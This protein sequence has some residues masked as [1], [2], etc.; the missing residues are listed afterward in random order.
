MYHPDD[1]V[2]DNPNQS[3]LIEQAAEMLYGLIHARY[4]LTN[5]GI[6]QMLEKYHAGD[7]GHCPRVYCENQLMLPIG[8]CVNHCFLDHQ[9]SECTNTL[10]RQVY[11]TSQ[12]RRWSSCTVR[13]VWMCTL[14]NLHATTTQME[15]ILER[16]SH[17]CSSW[18]T[19]NTGRRNPPTSLF[20]VCMV[21]KS[22]HWLIRSNSRVL[23]ISKCPCAPSTIMVASVKQL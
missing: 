17:T 3:D 16:D 4:I 13:N 18:F 7:F 2:E 8:I 9:F 15:R 14:Q 19:Q 21:S 5:R 1:D 12:V 22:I 6:L 11:L 20:L 23:L 10:I